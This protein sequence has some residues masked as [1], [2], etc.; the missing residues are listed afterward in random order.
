MKAN[1]SAREI[2]INL[3]MS[4]ELRNAVNKLDLKISIYWSFLQVNNQTGVR[5]LNDLLNDVEVS[6]ATQH[7][8]PV[9]RISNSMIGLKKMLG[10]DAFNDTIGTY[11]TYRLNHKN[12]ETI[13]LVKELRD[14]VSE[15]YYI[16]TKKTA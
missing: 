12:K 14:L 13:K 6:P 8:Y 9:T 3:P 5:I 10:E 15:V 16:K 11:K 1:L 4:K 7:R 2:F